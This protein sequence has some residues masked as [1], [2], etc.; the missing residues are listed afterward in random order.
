M[1]FFVDAYFMQNDYNEQSL[2]N[3]FLVNGGWLKNEVCGDLV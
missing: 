2:K 1:L 3:R